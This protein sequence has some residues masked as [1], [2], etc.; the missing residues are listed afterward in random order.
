MSLIILDKDKNDLCL[1]RDVVI[2][3]DNSPVLVMV[4]K[5]DEADEIL[6][7]SKSF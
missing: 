4:I 1:S 2:S 7:V 3:P 6:R 5:T